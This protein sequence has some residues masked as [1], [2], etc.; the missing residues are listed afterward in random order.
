MEVNV[1]NAP[2][3]AVGSLPVAFKDSTVIGCY[4]SDRLDDFNQ[5]IDELCCT[6]AKSVFLE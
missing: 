3:M 1:V 4:N 2:N 5:W 6:D